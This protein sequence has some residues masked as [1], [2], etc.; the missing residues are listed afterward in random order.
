MLHYA[1]ANGYIDAVQLLISEEDQKHVLQGQSALQ[2]EAA[3]QE[4]SAIL[5][6]ADVN[7]PTRQECYTP[8]YLAAQVGGMSVQTACMSAQS[9]CLHQLHLN[10]PCLLHADRCRMTT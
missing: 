7:L 2:E 9:S 3:L 10:R 1:A 4:C 8:L 6:I 5:T